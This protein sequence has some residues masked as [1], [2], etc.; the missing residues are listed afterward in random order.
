MVV[1]DRYHKNKPRDHDE[2]D[3]IGTSRQIIVGSVSPL[4]LAEESIDAG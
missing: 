3:S 2:R 4:F 1:D